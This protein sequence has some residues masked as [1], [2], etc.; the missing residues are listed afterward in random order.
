VDTTTLVVS[1][2]SAMALTLVVFFL[3]FIAAVLGAVVLGSG[4][5]DLAVVL[6]GVQQWLS[7]RLPVTGA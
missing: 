6:L 7:S 4:F 3:G 2:L 5:I 1:E